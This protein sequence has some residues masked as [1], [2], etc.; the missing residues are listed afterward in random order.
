MILNGLP[1]G[2]FFFRGYRF[3]VAKSSMFVPLSSLIP[4]TSRNGNAESHPLSNQKSFLFVS[5]EERQLG[6]TLRI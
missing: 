3:E 6:F 2:G 4:T 1:N 5:T